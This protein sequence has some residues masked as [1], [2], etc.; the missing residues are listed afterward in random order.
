M[1]SVTSQINEDNI[2]ELVH[3]LPFSGSIQFLPVASHAE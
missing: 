2:E 3:E 1:L